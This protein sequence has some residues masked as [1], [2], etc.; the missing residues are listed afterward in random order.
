MAVIDLFM[1]W[2]QINRRAGW[3]FPFPD[4]S[5]NILAG[6]RYHRTEG[7]PTCA[8]ENIESVQ[9]GHACSLHSIPPSARPACA[10]NIYGLRTPGACY[11]DKLSRRQRRRRTEPFAFSVPAR[12]SIS[13]S[14]FR[15]M[16]TKNLATTPRLACNL[17][18]EI[19]T[20]TPR[21]RILLGIPKT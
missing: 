13:S 21:T 7:T 18:C 6:P 9:P 2:R 4:E 8:A 16:E 5:A 17:V 1:R 19:L 3:L 15:T 14:V 10:P 11:D 20:K 12:S